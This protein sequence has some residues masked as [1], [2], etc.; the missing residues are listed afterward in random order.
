MISD[1]S[2]LGDGKMPKPTVNNSILRGL[3]LGTIDSSDSILRQ[4][5]KSEPTA[6]D[7]YEQSNNAMENITDNPDIEYIPKADKTLLNNMEDAKLTGLNYIIDGLDY[8]NNITRSIAYAAM[9]GESITDAAS[10]AAQYKRR[11]YS[12]DIRKEIGKKLDMNL[13]FS[14]KENEFDIGDIADFAADIV[15][16]MATD[17][18]T[19]LSLGT[20]KLIK[21]MSKAALPRTLRESQKEL[22]GTATSKLLNEQQGYVKLGGQRLGGKKSRVHG[23]AGETYKDQINTAKELGIINAIDIERA[24]AKAWD[25]SKKTGAIQATKDIY[26][27]AMG[28]LFN[29]AANIEDSESLGDTAVDFGIGAAAFVGG[30]KAV[31]QPWLRKRLSDI[32]SGLNKMVG[33]KETVHALAKNKKGK[34]VPIATKTQGWQMMEEAIKTGE[35][36]RKA[37]MKIHKPLESGRRAMVK[38]DAIEAA[39]HVLYAKKFDD[40]IND[41]R[42]E[43]WKNTLKGMDEKQLKANK[44]NLIEYKSK[45]KTKTRLPQWS[46][47]KNTPQSSQIKSDIHREIGS[48][49]YDTKIVNGQRV[50]TLNK[51]AM[52]QWIGKSEGDLTDKII[53]NMQIWKEAT[54]KSFV[55]EKDFYDRNLQMALSPDELQAS[56]MAQRKEAMQGLGK[57]QFD[58]MSH[59]RVKYAMEMNT[60]NDG[61][62]Y[63]FPRQGDK[64]LAATAKASK[65]AKKANL[66]RVHQRQ[67]M[68]ESL[69][70]GDRQFLGLDALEQFEKQRTL[71]NAEV[72]IKDFETLVD[73]ASKE[74]SKKTLNHLQKEAVQYSGDV[75]KNTKIYIKTLKRFN[76]L[77]KKGLLLGGYAWVK[78]NYWSN[79]RQAFS[80]HGLFGLIDSVK[81]APFVDDL[82][83]DIYNIYFKGGNFKEFAA[84]VTDELI[85]LGVIDAAHWKDITQRAESEELR[86]FL[87]S[88]D[89]IEKI[90]AEEAS[91]PL[92]LLKVAEKS[93]DK[94]ATLLRTKQLGGY[95]EAKARST[96]YLRTKDLLMKEAYEPLAEAF[97]RE[98]AISTIKNQAVKMTN[99]VFF[100]YSKL[101]YW[102]RSVAREFIPFYSFYKQ[103]LF[104]QSQ[105]LLDPKRVPYVATVSK[106][107]D[108]RYFGGE[109]VVGKDRELL[110]PYLRRGNAFITTDKDGQRYIN[111]TS[112]DPSQQAYQMWSKEYWFQDL[113]NQFNPVL[114]SA[115]TQISGWDFFRDE[116]LD[117]KELSKDPQRQLKYLYSRGY[118]LSYVYNI[119]DGL[120]NDTDHSTVWLDR[121]GNPVTASEAVARIDNVFSWLLAS[122]MNT[123]VQIGGQLGKM[124]H[125]KQSGWDT[126]MNLAGPYSSTKAIREQEERRMEE[127]E[128]RKFQ[129]DNPDL[130][131]S[132]RR[133]N[134]Q[135]VNQ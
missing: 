44:I 28:G 23:I 2:N 72:V 32:G 76:S 64:S 127:Y 39:T 40:H 104:Y 122:Y 55:I 52:R 133:L 62:L 109:P 65:E 108:G 34:Y 49:Y 50:N 66:K 121:K 4:L 117:P 111:Y 118:P 27:G 100:D 116:K 89:I 45:G 29:A 96:T 105:A 78:N 13:Q 41:L 36:S 98:A 19:Y 58:P 6:D 97:G 17:P 91:T 84:D 125:K 75:Y 86:K 8:A 131:D 113:M 24:S 9:R 48:R 93:A 73:I 80:N 3:D 25:M 33:P 37:Y 18:L 124:A 54:D 30:M 99:D 107:A 31:R 56:I 14:Q 87:W 10:D 92:K 59:S 132:L 21:T 26:A 46:E 60:A 135:R 53:E 123:P 5:E 1:I 42:N 35:L 129:E 95:V 20:S 103:N 88:D 47:V 119:M 94:M 12:E 15:I 112:S 77:V 128:E 83:K 68:S 120:I 7:I 110:T 85:E 22:V 82:S 57:K 43:L 69:K 115:I 90:T 74:K 102:E 130:M 16:D 101:T 70:N 61:L 38:G 134:R 71:A 114:M 81:I 67:A 11:V 79:M 126:L 63:W 106:M 51:D